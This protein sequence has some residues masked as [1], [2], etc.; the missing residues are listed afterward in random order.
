M[1]QGTGPPKDALLQPRPPSRLWPPPNIRPLLQGFFRDQTLQ[2]CPPKPRTHRHAPSKAQT[3]PWMPPWTRSHR[4]TTPLAKAQA[5]RE[6]PALQGQHSPPGTLGLS[7]PTHILACPC[8]LLGGAEFPVTRHVP[9]RDSRSGCAGREHSPLQGP[10][11]ARAPHCTAPAPTLCPPGLPETPWN[12][13]GPFQDPPGTPQDS[14]K[15]SPAGSL[16]LWNSPPSQPQATAQAAGS[17]V[18]LLAKEMPLREPGCPAPSPDC[19]QQRAGAAGDLASDGPG[20]VAR[21]AEHTQ[22]K[23]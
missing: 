18:A 3:P 2:G 7:T 8:T 21:P 14:P 13:P 9:P 6:A 10:N 1:P 4:D 17:L 19:G 12:P 20:G 16:G 15:T 11:P 23:S 5:P 22:G